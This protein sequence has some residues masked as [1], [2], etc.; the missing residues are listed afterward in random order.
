MTKIIKH[1]LD[2]DFGCK[3][4]FKYGRDISDSRNRLII[5]GA[6]GVSVMCLA[7]WQLLCHGFEYYLRLLFADGWLDVL[8][9]TDEW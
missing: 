9:G 7:L 5:I 6:H 2:Q 8:F 1:F 3:L 4:F